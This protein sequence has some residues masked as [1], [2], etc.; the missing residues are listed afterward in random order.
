MQSLTGLTMLLLL[1]GRVQRVV[2]RVARVAPSGLALPRRNPPALLALRPLSGAPAQG[3][4]AVAATDDAAPAAAPD[5][6]ATPGADAPADEAA[7]LRQLLRDGARA[8]SRVGPPGG[9]TASIEALLNSRVVKGVGPKLTAALVQRFGTRT[10]E[11]LRG[12]GSPEDEERLLGV[13]TLGPRK[14]ATIRESVSAWAEVGEAVEFSRGL[15]G[16][17]SEAQAAHVVS[18]YG[19][20]TERRVREDPYVLLRLFPSLRFQ[21]VDALARG[22]WLAIEGGNER[23]ARAA[24][25]HWMRRAL[26]NGHC[27]VPRARLVAEAARTLEIAREIARGEASGGEASGGRASGD[28]SARGKSGA[29]G[30][31]SRGATDVLSRADALAV[32]ERALDAQC[33][34]GEMVEEMPPGRTPPPPRA[35]GQGGTR[36]QAVA[37]VAPSAH[38]MISL[39]AVQAAERQVAIA[40]RTRL[41][42]P[43]SG[44]DAVF[45]RYEFE[46]DDASAPSAVGEEAARSSSTSNAHGGDYGAS[47]SGGF[48]L[49]LLGG[50]DGCGGADGGADGGGGS[51]GGGGG[52]AAGASG[53]ARGVERGSAAEH[54]ADDTYSMASAQSMAT[55]PTQAQLSALQA[56]AVE[57][58]QQSKLLLLTGGP[59]T[60]KTFTVRAIVQRWRASGHRVL[61]ACP[62]ARAA[63]VLASAVGAPASTIH[64]LLK[65]NP[66]E[67]RFKRNAAEP[68]E[69]EA[70]VVDEASMLDVHLAGALFDALRPEVGAA[71]PRYAHTTHTHARRTRTHEA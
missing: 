69:A 29:G 40:V 37:K 41:A 70:L 63:S 9:S 64:R 4:E 31:S 52:A 61:L 59:G 25:E 2:P 49:G 58:A 13:S 56:E 67:E 55:Q 32:A 62:T 19:A 8:R 21:T 43:E 51:G 23:R 38:P 44:F 12:D 60:G 15:V 39:P 22:P 71:P 11:V 42:P 10:L 18:Q 27:S 68:L 34:A 45:G 33:E 24:L 3:W 66:R 65:W 46:S 54:G 35:G 16:V 50:D 48:D 6:S 7:T 14:L 26:A 20:D 28:E 30:A 1:L 47:R 5:A 53:R 57:R 17:L 36:G